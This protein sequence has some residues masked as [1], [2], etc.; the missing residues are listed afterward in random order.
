M[1]PGRTQAGPWGLPVALATLGTLVLTVGCTPAPEAGDPAESHES[2]AGFEPGAPGA[3]LPSSDEAA[4][5]VA[6]RRGARI[7]G[8]LAEI[9]GVVRARVL[10]AARPLLPRAHEETLPVATA[11]VYVEPGAADQ[12]TAA[13]VRTFVAGALG[14]RDERVN[15]FIEVMSEVTP[16]SVAASTAAASLHRVGPLQLS[17]PSAGLLRGL[18]WGGALLL[19]LLGGSLLWMVSRVRGA[20]RGSGAG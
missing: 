15:A 18:L 14:V 2:S 7:A 1:N 13:R 8:A 6:A 11:V 5:G 4:D 10:V 12:W 17:P 19:L 20:R 9:S 16:S 3:L